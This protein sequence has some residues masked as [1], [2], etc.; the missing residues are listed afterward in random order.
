MESIVSGPGLVNVFHF[1]N[2]SNDIPSLL[3][4]DL[5]RKDCPARIVQG[6]T[7]KNNT[8][9][10][11]LD[12]W[13]ECL[14]CHLRLTSMQLLPTGGLYICG[15]IPCREVVLN[16]IRELFSPGMFVD[17]MVMGE[18]LEKNVSLHVVK[19]PDIGLMGAK[20]RAVRLLREE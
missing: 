8:C 14:A 12:L 16:R 11:S 10:E 7:E 19:N 15:G 4:D 6:V 17:D 1:C 5:D 13:L 18:Y 2:A 20:V 3:L 9:M